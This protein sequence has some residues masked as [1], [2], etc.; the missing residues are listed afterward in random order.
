MA[1]FKIAG[2]AVKKILAKDLDL[3]KTLQALF[4]QNLE[5]LMGSVAAK[6]ATVQ[7]GNS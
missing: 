5:E 6:F 2:T 7:I 3:E 1:L 4:E